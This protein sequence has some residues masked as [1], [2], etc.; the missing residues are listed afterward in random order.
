[1]EEDK[2]IASYPIPLKAQEIT[3]PNINDVLE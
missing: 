1:M 3:V 2:T